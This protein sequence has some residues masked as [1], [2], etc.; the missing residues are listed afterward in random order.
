MVNGTKAKRSVGFVSLKM[1]TPE[2]FN[3]IISL[4]CVIF[5][6][7]VNTASKKDMGRVIIIKSGIVK[8]ASFST[9]VILT[10]LLSTIWVSS[11]ILFIVMLKVNIK[12]PNIKG[13]I[14][15]LNMYLSIVDIP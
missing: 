12:S 7:T 6:K 15:C 14:N 10:P 9:A 1:E 2:T 11:K 13:G 3:A 8:L 5:P 4:S